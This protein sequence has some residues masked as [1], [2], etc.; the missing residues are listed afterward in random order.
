MRSNV[1]AG[2]Y[3]YPRRDPR[4]SVRNSTLVILGGVALFVL[5]VP[6]TFVLGGLAILAG[7]VA[8]LLGW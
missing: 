5:P 1:V 4:E 6:G 7:L 8:R 2:R 3:D